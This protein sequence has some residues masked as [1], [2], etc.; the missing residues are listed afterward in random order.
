MCSTTTSTTVL[1]T[2]SLSTLEADSTVEGSDSSLGADSGSASTAAS[3]IVSA[4]LL[5]YSP[6]FQ[7]LPC[8]PPCRLSSPSRYATNLPSKTFNC[9]LSVPARS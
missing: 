8:T 1:E 3:V 4:S 5:V 6:G 9:K 7:S 2:E